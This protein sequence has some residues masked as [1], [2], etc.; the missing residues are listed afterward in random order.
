MRRPQPVVSWKTGPHQNTDAATRTPLRP[1]L[2]TFERLLRYL[3][4]LK[5]PKLLGKR[6]KTAIIYNYDNNFKFG[7]TVG[8]NTPNFLVFLIL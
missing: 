5:N 1:R 8:K 6:I 7:F 2:G 4:P 3:K